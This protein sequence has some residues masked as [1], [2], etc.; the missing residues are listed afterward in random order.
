MELKDIY[1]EEKLKNSLHYRTD[2]FASVY[3]EN[4]GD[5]TFKVKDLSNMSQLSNLNYF[6]PPKMPKRLFH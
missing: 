5:S 6:M 2:T 3:V 1:G 4:M